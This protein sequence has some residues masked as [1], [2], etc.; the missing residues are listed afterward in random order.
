MPPSTPTWLSHPSKV[1]DFLQTAVTH[2][3][4]LHVNNH[5]PGVLNLV[6]TSFSGEM[7]KRSPIAR[8]ARR[9]IFFRTAF[10]QKRDRL[11]YP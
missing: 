4:F 1:D 7:E 6:I 11:T 3:L 9:H 10:Q 2:V 5:A 8:T